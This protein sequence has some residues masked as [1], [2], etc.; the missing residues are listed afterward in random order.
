MT[1]EAIGFRGKR[2]HFGTLKWRLIGLIVPMLYHTPAISRHRSFP[3]FSPL[4]PIEI[5]TIV[6]K[7]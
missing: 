3:R 4:D 7:V 6:E 2:N 5:C 1:A